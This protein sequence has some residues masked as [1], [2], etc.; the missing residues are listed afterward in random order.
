MKQKTF[1]M[2]TTRVIQQAIYPTVTAL[3]LIGMYLAITPLL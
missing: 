1:F 3:F 2:K